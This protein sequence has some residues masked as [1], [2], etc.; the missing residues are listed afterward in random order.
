[1]HTQVQTSTKIGKTKTIS[2]NVLPS[3]QQR[4]KHIQKL[5]YSTNPLNSEITIKTVD[6]MVVHLPALDSKVVTIIQTK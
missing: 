2:K 4:K 3:N 5:N 1:M 6:R